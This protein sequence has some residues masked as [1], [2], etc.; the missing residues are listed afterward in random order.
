V[1]AP[2]AD[3]RVPADSLPSS[4]MDGCKTEGRY[5]IHPACEGARIFHKNNGYACD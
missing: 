5:N 3:I 4:F 2:A 1:A